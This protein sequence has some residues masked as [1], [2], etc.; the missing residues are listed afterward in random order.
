MSH[1]VVIDPWIDPLDLL[2]R[3]NYAD[4]LTNYLVGRSDS[5]VLNLNASW[6]MGKTYF[7]TH[8]RESIKNAHPT[9]Y[10]NAWKS[11]FS[12]DPLLA[13]MSAIHDQ[14]K[15]HLPPEQKTMEGFAKYMKASGRF[16]KGLAPVVVKGLI[17]KAIGKDATEDLF[18]LSTNELAGI[19]EKSMSLLLQEHIDKDK[20]IDSFQRTLVELVEKVTER[21]EL[22]APLFVFIDELDRCRPT[23]AIEL[24][25]TVKHLFSVKG[26]VFVIATDSEQLQHSV[27][28]IYGERFSGRE[29]LRRFFDQEYI[30]PEPSYDSYCLTLAEGVH[31]R[32]KLLYHKF[33]TWSRNDHN[34]PKPE[35]WSDSDNL[36]AFLSLYARHY[37]LPL[38]SI[39]QMVVRLEA[40]INSI[41]TR[42]DAPF[43]LFLLATQ[44]KSDTRIKAIKEVFTGRASKDDKHTLINSIGIG[45]NTIRWLCGD[46]YNH[47]SKTDHHYDIKNIANSYISAIE[48]F[49]NTPT[50]KRPEL[51]N[52]GTN[53]ESYVRNLLVAPGMFEQ[54]PIAD[55]T[56]YVDYVEM[57]GALA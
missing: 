34:H 15:N 24:L 4:F 36:S 10:V 3:K 39:N 22:T 42:W 17:N 16:A 52:E 19:A 54:Q 41:D 32:D 47:Q 5:F 11:D 13:V 51:T 57:A 38:R 40:I 43:L 21:K 20:S 26:I 56:K 6:G 29:Y 35:G 1:S 46:R 31:G 48:K 27:C 14:L 50:N 28:A 37:N 49:I 8:W 7:L 18:E 55:I 53:L 2:D 9:V 33:E 12:D 44:T 25:E 30:L 23:Y 45:E